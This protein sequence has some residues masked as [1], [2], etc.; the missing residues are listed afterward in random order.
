[1]LEVGSEVKKMK[2]IGYANIP[3]HLEEAVLALMNV[4]KEFPDLGGLSIRAETKRSFL[5]YRNTIN[6]YS[7][8]KSLLEKVMK[9]TEKNTFWYY[10]Q[11]SV[12]RSDFFKR[13]PVDNSIY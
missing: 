3:R 4:T 5:Q 13:N 10:L 9:K 1:L 6:S 12:M 8:N 11:F 7:S 2:D